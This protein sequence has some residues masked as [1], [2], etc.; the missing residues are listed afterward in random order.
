VPDFILFLDGRGLIT[1]VWNGG[2]LAYD[3]R[4]IACRE[5][6]TRL[7]WRPAPDP[8]PGICQTVPVSVLKQ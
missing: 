6:L 2:A 4:A 1:R 5:A 3:R 8:R 7:R